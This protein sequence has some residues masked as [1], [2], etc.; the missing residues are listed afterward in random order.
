MDANNTIDVLKVGP[1]LIG[2]LGG[3]AFFLY[4][5][6]HLTEALKSIASSRMKLLLAHFTSNRLKAAFSGAMITAVIQSSSITTLLVVGF[7]S[8]G[9]MSLSQSIGVI[10]GANIGTTFTAQIIAFKI[11]KYAM[12][13]IVVGFSILF[14]SRQN[15]SRQYGTLLL[16]LGLIFYGMELMGYAT[17]PLRSY[18]PFINLMSQ[19]DSPLQG[20]LVGAFFTALIQSSSATTGVVIVLGSQ[21][22]LSLEGGIA[23]IFGA[24][25]G[26][27]VTALLASIKKPREAIQAAVIHVLFNLLGVLIW[28][29]FIDELAM[30]VRII[31]PVFKDIEAN[32]RVSA[33]IPRQIANAHTLFNVSNTLLFI[34]FTGPLSAFV[35]YLIPARLES[36]DELMRPKY[37]DD[38]FLQAP[39]MALERVRM[40]LH[41]LGKYALHMVQEAFQV[42][43]HGSRKDL[44][45]LANMDNKVDALHEIIVTYLGRL[46][47]NNLTSSQS[48]LLYDYIAIVNYIENIGDMI[49]TNIVEAGINRLNHRVQISESTQ[50]ILGALHKKVCWSV[51]TSLDVI[52]KGDSTRATEVVTAKSEINQLASVAESHLVNRLTAEEVNRFTLYRI[53]SEIIEYLKRVYYFAKRINRTI[54]K[55]NKADLE[56]GTV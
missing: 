41:R 54:L 39:D 53:E 38:I 29:A 17:N 35:Q 2:L 13:L 30:L 3:L 19:M 28:V 26:T 25:V 31:S 10:M 52:S 40:E 4:G 49:E 14:F 47:L 42:V 16:G 56:N 24:N 11:T 32:A 36:A 44:K 55:E 20:I 8:S 21:G 51:E 27:C 7:V 45:K 18:T 22:F 34:W 6:E 48:K 5:I 12:I 33:E 23:L 1:I 15:Q 50:K 43:I 46:S 9:L 37:L